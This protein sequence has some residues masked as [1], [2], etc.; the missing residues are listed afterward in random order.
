MTR[1]TT[2]LIIERFDTR[3][4]APFRWPMAEDTTAALYMQFTKG[5]RNVPGWPLQSG[6]L[7]RTTDI[8]LFFHR[9]NVK[10]NATTMSPTAV[11]QSREQFDVNPAQ[12]ERYVGLP[13]VRPLGVR[14]PPGSDIFYFVLRLFNG[15]RTETVTLRSTEAIMQWNRVTQGLHIEHV[16]HTALVTIP[17]TINENWTAVLELRFVDGSRDGAASHCTLS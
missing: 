10:L 17:D 13:H 11:W 1:E 14:G 9:F 15:S 12:W 16:D 4:T 7:E 5:N 3:D 2:N 8:A 6:R